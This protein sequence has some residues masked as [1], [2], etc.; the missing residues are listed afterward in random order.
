MPQLYILNMEGMYFCLDDLGDMRKML[1]NWPNTDVSIVVV[2]DGS[3]ILGFGDMGINGIAVPVSA[4]TLE[5]S[6]LVS[7]LLIVVDK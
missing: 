6:C 5:H 7:Q 1:D 2:T 4:V 3:Q